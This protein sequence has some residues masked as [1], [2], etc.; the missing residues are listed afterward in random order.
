[1]KELYVS[2]YTTLQ[3]CSKLGLQYNS[4]LGTRSRAWTTIQLKSKDQKQT[5]S[6]GRNLEDREGVQKDQTRRADNIQV[7]DIL[8]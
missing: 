6:A 4:S 3:G 7:T 1:M 8:R 5:Q 2:Y